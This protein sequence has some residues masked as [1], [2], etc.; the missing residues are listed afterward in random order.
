MSF[1]ADLL[2][3]MGEEG[4]EVKR[5]GG[6]RGEWERGEERMETHLYEQS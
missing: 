3:E 2:E 6:R 5:R 4:G 1:K